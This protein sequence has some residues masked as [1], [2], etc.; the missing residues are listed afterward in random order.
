MPMWVIVFGTAR[1]FL[2]W[3]AF[4]ASRYSLPLYPAILI[5]SAYGVFESL[6][7]LKNKLPKRTMFSSVV[8]SAIILYILSVYS[9]RGYAVSDINSQTFVGYEQ[10]GEF[11]MTHDSNLTILTP[12]PQQMKYYA[13][14]FTVYDMDQSS[15]IDH[16]EK[17]I[18]DKNINFVSIDKWSPHQPDWCRNYS[19]TTH[20]YRLV[21][22]NKNIAIFKEPKI[23]DRK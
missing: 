8:F 20:G 19:W 22:D 2:P 7:F 21:F 12:S 16:I 4:R 1:F 15:T 23:S 17:L 9:I 13:P 6:D 10:A 5:F 14:E 18:K 11:L 3:L